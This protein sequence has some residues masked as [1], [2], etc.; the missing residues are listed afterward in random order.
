MCLAVVF[1]H[2]VTVGFV[3]L[4]H[5]WFGIFDQFWKLCRHYLLI[6]FFC[7]IFY[8]FFSELYW[9][10][11]L[12]LVIL[13]FPFCSFFTFFFFNLATSFLSIFKFTNPL[14]FCVCCKAYLLNSLFLILYF[15]FLEFLFFVVYI[16]FEIPYLFLLNVQSF[17]FFLLIAELV[18]SVCQF[19]HLTHLCSVYCF[20]FRLLHLLL[21]YCMPCNILLHCFCIK[22]KTTV[23][24][25]ISN[26]HFH[27]LLDLE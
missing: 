25:E 8:H 10:S 17:H 15:S 6:C 4:L 11:M 19:W 18:S 23:E 20:V 21:L 5:I 14:L 9:H 7:L 27:A 22:Y 12:D 3:E 16:S 13:D 24:N 1:L 26:T 2:L